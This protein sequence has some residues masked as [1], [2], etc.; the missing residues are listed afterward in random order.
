[1]Y[2]FLY[3]TV[4]E[5][6]NDDN[7]AHDACRRKC[8]YEN[9]KLVDCC[10]VRT[11]YASLTVDERRRYIGTVIRAAS[12]PNFR[13]RYEALVTK[14]KSS[15]DTIAQDTRSDVSVFFPWQRYFLLEYEN[16]LREIDCRITIPYWDW[17][18]L[19]MNPYMSA[20]WNPEN[21]FGD[22]SRAND[23]CVS[24]G[25]FNFAVFAITPGAGG[26]CLQ[27][28][29]RI[30]LFPTRA[31]IEQDLLTI[32]PSEFNEFH[33]FLQVFIHTNVRCFVG[34]Q[35]CSNNAANDPAYLLHLS[36]LDYLFTRWQEIHEAAQFAN[37]NRS[38]PLTASPVTV[39]Q[40]SNNQNLPNDVK[41]C[42]DPAEFKSHVP[43]S[44]L[45]L[46]DALEAI[47]QNHNLYMECVDD[48][49]MQGMIM[50]RDAE[51]F[52][53]KMCDKEHGSADDGSP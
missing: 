24:N 53:H 13:P 16:L 38:L 20:V 48:G 5:C 46:S 44:M 21:G 3:H 19:P 28:Q 45:F 8:R 30:Q 37:D 49:D 7:T 15:F 33:Q 23:S 51:N 9:G 22:S 14:Y 50:G 10:R 18:A 43:R 2:V 35:M 4:A 31:I 34:G 6:S 17:T 29:Y 40:F 1:M 52:M 26:G 36:Q 39:S 11:D 47:T 12:D 27:R 41:M 25:P 32:Q 42:Y